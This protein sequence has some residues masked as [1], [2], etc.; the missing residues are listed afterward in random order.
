MLFQ[1]RSLVLKALFFSTVLDRFFLSKVNLPVA[2]QIIAPPAGDGG[3]YMFC[4]QTLK[5]NKKHRQTFQNTAFM[6]MHQPVAST[7]VPGSGSFLSS[8]QKKN[9]C[10]F[11][12]DYRAMIINSSCQLNQPIRIPK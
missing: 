3:I 10:V 9:V 12:V 1:R 7:L 4:L 2:S 5:T 11:F 8:P 6:F